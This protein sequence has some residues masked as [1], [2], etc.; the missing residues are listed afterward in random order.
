VVSAAE[1][2]SPA[3]VK[4]D[5]RRRMQPRGG[6]PR[7]NGGSGSGFVFTPDGLTLTN[8][9]VASGASKLIVAFNAA[10]A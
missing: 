10:F 9:H 3:V 4:I 5:V 7:E 8:G 6:G 2:V 1:R